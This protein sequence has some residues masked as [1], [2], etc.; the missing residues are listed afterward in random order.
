MSDFADL[1]F[2]ENPDPRCAVVLV[3]DVS[4]SMAET[5]DGDSRPPIAALNEGLDTLVAELTADPL[6]SRRVEVAIVTFG[7]SV[8]VAADFATTAAMSLPVLSAAGPTPLG[9][10]LDRALDLV[11]DRKRTYRANGVTYY[12]PWVVLITDGLPTDEWSA[13]ATRLKE[14]QRTKSL[15]FFPVAVEGADMKML[16]ELSDTAP[17]LLAGTKFNELFVWLSASQARVSG[18]QPGDEVALPSPAGWASV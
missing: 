5:R 6:A 16:A 4:G 13:A 9:A 15:A 7:A 17:L 10:A 18:S 14:A 8:D 11:E 12:R 2:A 3:L 1:T